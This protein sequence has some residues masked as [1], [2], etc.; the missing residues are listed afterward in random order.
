MSCRIVYSQQSSN[1]I[2]HR[3]ASVPLPLRSLPAEAMLL[4]QGLEFRLFNKMDDVPVAALL[5]FE[6]ELLR[7]DAP[8]PLCDP[9]LAVAQVVRAG[10]VEGLSVRWD[11]DVPADGDDLGATRQHRRISSGRVGAGDHG[12]VG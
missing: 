5:C 9:Q 2:C 8:D 11:R 12:H 10:Q 7:D 3:D 1:R 4:V 6:H